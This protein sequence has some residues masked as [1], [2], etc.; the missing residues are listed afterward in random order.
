MV[1]RILD[2]NRLIRWWQ[3]RRPRSTS[4]AQ[5]RAKGLIE[6]ERTNKIVTPVRLEFLSGTTK[7]DLTLCDVF[8]AEFEI[9]DKGRILHEDWDEAARFARRSSNRP[10]GA[11]DCL[12]R[13]IASR[14]HCEVL[15]DDKRFP[16]Q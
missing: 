15:T 11:M 8:L 4:E 13:A 14:L 7:D 16:P 2:T 9:L 1:R 10:R 5:Q 3:Q 12:I 6:R